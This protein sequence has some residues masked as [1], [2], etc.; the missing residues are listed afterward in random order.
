MGATSVVQE[1][2]FVI[3]RGVRV[4]PLAL[5]MYIMWL[6]IKGKLVKDW[7]RGGIT[8]YNGK[9]RMVATVFTKTG[10]VVLGEEDVSS[11]PSTLAMSSHSQSCE[12]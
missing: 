1:Y 11:S 8:L 9:N 10:D 7:P 3:H 2:V 5:L 6:Y 12:P 4:W